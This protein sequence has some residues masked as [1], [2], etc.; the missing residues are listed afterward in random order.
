M[1]RTG[2]VAAGT[3]FVLLALAAHSQN[4][5]QPGPVPQEGTVAPEFTAETVDG[6]RVSLSDAR[7]RMVLLVFWSPG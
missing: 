3:L 6:R 1:R 2:F 7:G 4:A 5:P